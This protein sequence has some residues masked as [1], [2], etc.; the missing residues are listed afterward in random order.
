M[1]T[2]LVAG[3]NGSGLRAASTDAYSAACRLHHWP[4]VCL[5]SYLQYYHP[6]YHAITI[7]TSL[8]SSLLSP[9]TTFSWDMSSMYLPFV[10]SMYVT[11]PP[12]Y[13]LTMPPCCYSPMPPRTCSCH[14]LHTH[15]ISV[16]PLLGCGH[17]LCSSS[18]ML[19]CATI[20][21]QHSKR[22]NLLNLFL[23]LF[24]PTIWTILS[25]LFTHCPPPHLPTPL[26][27]CHLPCQHAARETDSPPT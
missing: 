22:V 11:P 4:A 8:T 25:A 19:F 2:Y 27:E 17:W 9:M 3:A 15:F 18:S 20:L 5:P 13:M 23:F 24:S 21:H 10:T 1:R 16:L 12:Y 26:P 6:I 14:L 7:T